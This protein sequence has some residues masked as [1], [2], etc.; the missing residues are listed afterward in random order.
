MVFTDV[1]DGIQIEIDPV[2][3]IPSYNFENSGWINS[4]G[5]MRITPSIAE[6][7]KMP[8]KYNIV[9]TD[10]DSAYVGVSRSGTVRDENG[11]SIGSDKI[12][13]PAI[14]F[15]VQNTSF[16]DTSTGQYLSLIHISEPTR[17]Y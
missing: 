15:Y 5:I 11:S 9:F 2:V 3:E 13:E 4:S 10:D 17:P 6:G 12:T 7:V 14:N 8:W 16:V 1:F